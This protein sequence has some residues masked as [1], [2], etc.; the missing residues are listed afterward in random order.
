MTDA[1]YRPVMK[2]CTIL[3]QLLGSLALALGKGALAS[4]QKIPAPETLPHIT[5]LD[6]GR[7]L[8]PI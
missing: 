2:F 8:L 4:T 3:S 5:Q 7:M 6:N 1:I